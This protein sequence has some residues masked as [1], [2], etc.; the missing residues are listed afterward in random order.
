MILG[1]G[2]SAQDSGRVGALGLGA[3]FIG[4]LPVVYFV[5]FSHTSTFQLLDKPWSQVSSLL[6]PGSC[7]QNLSRA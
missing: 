2:Y 1:L 5:F 6:P 7:L 3:R 4:I